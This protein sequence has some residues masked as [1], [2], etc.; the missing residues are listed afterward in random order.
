MVEI[1][2]LVIVPDL[3]LHFVSGQFGS[4]L[5]ILGAGNIAVT[6]AWAKSLVGDLLDYEAGFL[7]H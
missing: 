7:W 6:R 5:T 4:S 3:A 2:D 1:G